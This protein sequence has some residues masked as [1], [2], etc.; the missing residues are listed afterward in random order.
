MGKHGSGKCICNFKLNQTKNENLSRPSVSLLPDSRPPAF[1]Q[2]AADWLTPVTDWK[3]E[4]TELDDTRRFE[5]TRCSTRSPLKPQQTG[6]K[7]FEIKCA[8]DFLSGWRGVTVS[9]YR[10]LYLD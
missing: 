1:I 6:P 3:R 2:V 9:V 10:Q 4:N 5:E 8:H 7:C